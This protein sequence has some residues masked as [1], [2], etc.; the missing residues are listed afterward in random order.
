MNAREGQSSHNLILSV[1][2]TT[3]SSSKSVTTRPN[4]TGSNTNYTLNSVSLVMFSLDS[5]RLKLK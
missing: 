2:G 4:L 3:Q 1:F 5:R